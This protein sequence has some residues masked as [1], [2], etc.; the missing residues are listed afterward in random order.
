M[1]FRDDSAN[2]QRLRIAF[3]TTDHREHFKDYNNPQPYF[4]SAPKALLQGFRA[5]PNEV[6]VHV[7]S[8]LQ[9]TPI[10][11][12]NKLADNIYYHGLHV[13]NIGWMKTGYLG[14]IRA[15]RDKLQ[16]I[17]PDIVHGQGTERDCAMCAVF[18]GFPNVLT[19]HGNMRMVAEFLKAKPL[20]YYWFASRIERLCLWKT[21]GVVAISS[22]T[23]SNVAPYT[24]QTWLVPNA[25][26]SSFFNLPRRPDSPPRILCA[27]NTGSRKNQIGLIKALEPLAATRPLKL[28]LAGGGSKADVYFRNFQQLVGERPWCEYLG[29]L[30]QN[31]LQNE[32]S[33]ATMGIL[34]SF[35][36]NCPM[37]ILEA[38]AAGL[39]FAASA[40]G[41]IPDLIAHGDNGML[42]SPDKSE[43]IQSAVE[44][45]LRNSEARER[46]AAC[47]H[48]K[49]EARCH[50]LVVARD[51]LR[52]YMRVTAQN[53]HR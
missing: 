37:V 35:E 27:A 2:S 43:E 51:H 39:P 17:Q 5:M 12:P 34:P 47:A 36:D 22:Y 1:S 50:P 42:F 20:T 8:C 49:A 14:C 6:E 45:L 23:Q 19:I 11:S 15:V 4:G 16:E 18:S 9:K 41:G 7:I 53:E 24:K 25:V 13:P 46:L 52:I 3:V 26:H 40:I 30:D 10:S 48:R 33:R 28:I 32:M 21:D 29:A 31:T 44:Y 38:A